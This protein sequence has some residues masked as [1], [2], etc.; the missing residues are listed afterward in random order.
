[1]TDIVILLSAAVVAAPLFQYPWVL[2]RYRD[3]LGLSH[4]DWQQFRSMVFF[5]V[6][7]ARSKA[8][9]IDTMR[10]KLM[11]AWYRVV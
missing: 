6:F 5:M 8:E 4:V 1:L 3:L 7:I 9:D 10:E 2:V 11:L